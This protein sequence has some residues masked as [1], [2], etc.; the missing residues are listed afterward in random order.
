MFQDVAPDS[1]FYTY[2]QALASRYIMSGYPCGGENDPCGPENMPYF[3]PN[4]NATRGQTAKI[5]SNTFSPGC[6]P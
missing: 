6:N 2:V 5:V 3:H 4:Q 1:V